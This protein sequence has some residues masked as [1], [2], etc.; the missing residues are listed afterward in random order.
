MSVAA[1][2]ITRPA[3]ILAR[4]GLRAGNQTEGRPGAG[5]RRPGPRIPPARLLAAWEMKRGEQRRTHPG[6]DVVDCCYPRGC[7]GR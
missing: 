7:A 4:A 5:K 6:G 1:G 2:L 3:S